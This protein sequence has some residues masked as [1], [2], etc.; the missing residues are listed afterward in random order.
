M[1]LKSSLYLSIYFYYPHYIYQYVS[2]ILIISIN[3]FL[4]SSL[5]LSIYFDNPHYIY[6]YIFIIL[7]IF[8]NMYLPTLP[9]L[10]D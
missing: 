5:Y 7:I 6:Q 3:M 8:A 2:I 4:K 1:F 9:P 10:Q